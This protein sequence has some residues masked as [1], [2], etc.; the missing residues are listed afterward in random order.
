[1]RRLACL[2]ALALLTGCNLVITHKP[3]FTAADG[4]GAP[5]LHL[6]MLALDQTRRAIA[7]RRQSLS[8]ENQLISFPAPRHLPAAE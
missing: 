2:L 6:V 8:R 7:D 1:M 5:S 3:M 4:A